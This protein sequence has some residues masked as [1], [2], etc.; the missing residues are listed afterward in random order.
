LVGVVGT[1][2]ATET[3]KLL[4]G[5][6]RSLM[7]RLLMIDARAMEFTEMRIGRNASCPVCAGR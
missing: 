6:G 7:G 1:M 4:A 5:V 2:Q 3:L